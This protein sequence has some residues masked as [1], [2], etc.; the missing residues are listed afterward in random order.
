[1][2]LPLPGFPKRLRRLARILVGVHDR[3]LQRQAL[4]ELDDRMLKD[5]GLT[6]AERDRECGRSPWDG[7]AWR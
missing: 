6:R 2:T 7:D 5:I 1:V 4:A 3:W